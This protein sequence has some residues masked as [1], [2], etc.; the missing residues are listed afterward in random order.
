MI[1][2]LYNKMKLNYLRAKASLIPEKYQSQF[3]CVGGASEFQ[4]HIDLLIPED[5]RK[6]LVVGTHGGRDYFHIL[7]RGGEA[8]GLNLYPNNKMENLVVGNVED[9][10]IFLDDSFDA[11]IFSGTIE[12]VAH[13]FKALQNIYSWLRKDGILLLNTVYLADSEDTHM[14]LYSPKT[15]HRLVTAAGFDVDRRDGEIQNPS[16]FWYPP[17][18]NYPHHLLNAVWFM[19]TGKTLYKWTLPILWKIDLWLSTGHGLM[20]FCRRHSNNRWG[21]TLKCVKSTKRDYVKENED[22]FHD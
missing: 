7:A 15:L 22:K 14:R 9:R 16:L 5:R 21:I 13:D 11:V 3:V 18:F 19:L 10:S 12:H 17:M 2:S 8:W 6:V 1:H 4:Y 20:E